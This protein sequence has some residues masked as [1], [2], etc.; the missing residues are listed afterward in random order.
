MSKIISAVF[1]VAIA[2]FMVIGMESGVEARVGKNAQLARELSPDCPTCC[3]NNL[4]AACMLPCD[5]YCGPNYRRIVNA[6]RT[7]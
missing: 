5:Q 2:V 6:Y 7:G 4:P 3:Y 1:L